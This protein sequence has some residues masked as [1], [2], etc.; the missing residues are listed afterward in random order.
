MGDKLAAR[1]RA[2]AADVP[3]VP[4]I[5]EPLSV[6]TA[7]DETRVAAQA[8]EIGY[9]VLVKAA[10]GGGGRGMRRVD[11]RDD[12]LESIQG[13]SREAAAA[14]GDGSVYIERYV[15]RARHVEVQLLGDAFGQIVALGERDCS[16]QRRHQKLVEEA[17]APGLSTDQ[18][19]ILHGLGVKV[20]ATVGL[21]DAATAEFLLTP[22][23][24]FWFLRST[25]DSRS[26]M[27]SP[28]WSASSTWCMSRSPSPQGCRY[29][30]ASSPRPYGPQSRSVTPSRSA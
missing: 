29:P 16:T 12:L 7:D 22:T 28:S 21:R 9:P 18:R 10:A 26:S 23:G 15:E 1:R 4:G 20:A 14:F 8:E 19:R 13:A 24:D 6:S 11:E 5:F 2:T 27:A 25:P 30:I 17:P 3:V